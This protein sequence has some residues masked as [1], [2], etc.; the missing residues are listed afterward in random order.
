MA[1][2]LKI[3]VIDLMTNNPR[4]IDAIKKSGLKINKRIPITSESNDYNRSYLST[5]AKKLGHLM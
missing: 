2:H 5:K 4:K 3:K 1:N